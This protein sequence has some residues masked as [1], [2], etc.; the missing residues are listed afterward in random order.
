MSKKKHTIIDGESMRPIAKQYNF[1][2]WRTIYDYQPDNTA[3][4]EANPNNQIVPKPVVII[5]D[6]VPKEESASTGQTHVFAVPTR[7]GIWNLKWDPKECTLGKDATTKL[8][9][10]TDLPEGAL[11]V[12]AMEKTGEGPD[13]PQIAGTVKG[14]KISATWSLKDLPPQKPAHKK[15]GKDP[16]PT[17]FRSYDSDGTN[18]CNVAYL[19]LH[20]VVSKR[21]WKIHWEPP[22]VTVA[23]N[24]LSVLVAET[25][26]SEG[27]SATFE[28]S[29]LSNGKKPHLTGKADG[30]GVIRMDWV[31]V[32]EEYPED[33]GK[34]IK[35]E[36]KDKLQYWL[37]AAAFN[38]PADVE[39]NTA[40]LEVLRLL[41]KDVVFE[42]HCSHR[43]FAVNTYCELIARPGLFPNQEHAHKDTLRVEAPNLAPG[44]TIRWRINCNI[45]HFKSES[46][47][48]QIAFDTDLWQLDNTFWLPDT[49]GREY[50]IFANQYPGGPKRI[51]TLVYPANHM[52]AEIEQKRGYPNLTSTVD[53]F[54]KLAKTNVTKPVNDLK[55]TL[56]KCWDTLLQEYLTVNAAGLK[57]GLKTFAEMKLVGDMG[58]QEYTDHRCYFAHDVELSASLV[59]P[60]FKLPY[61]GA[62][63][64]YPLKKVCA[65]MK[66]GCL[67]LQM[68]GS[69]GLAG[70]W[71]REPRRFTA[72]VSV[73]SD[74]IPVQVS[75]VTARLK[76]GASVSIEGEYGVRLIAD[77]VPGE[78][79]GFKYQ[80]K[81]EGELTATVRSAQGVETVA[82]KPFRDRDLKNIFAEMQTVKFF[83]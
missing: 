19:K 75:V 62:F 30:G 3:F 17:E 61:K 67:E 72:E 32:A 26:L 82:F 48:R 13:A 55:A 25:D 2:D 37:K 47:G 74:Y 51:M 69:L 44:A 40:D 77:K 31:L 71:V 29:G 76:K 20:P 35:D 54:P 80:M 58:W 28:V 16:P 7:R 39:C 53:T 59:E 12:F 42:L 46:E 10:D 65:D 33:K 81:W 64:P 63:L 43:S 24:E 66:L 73:T 22:R 38:K 52:H 14:G 1:F 5:P 60:N 78:H 36:E 57:K 68:K 56:G 45:T 6:K 83:E 34:K 15:D 21:V 41:S 49:K 23:V 70:S 50:E 9:G 27:E 18:T 79:A 4:A 8:G 11:V